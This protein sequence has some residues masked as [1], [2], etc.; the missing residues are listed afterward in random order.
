[1][2]SSIAANYAATYLG[3]I[4]G[5]VR[6]SDR[7]GNSLQVNGSSNTTS[8]NNVGPDTLQLSAKGRLLAMND[9]TLPTAS[10]V[11]ALSA[12][13]SRD[14]NDLFLKAGINTKTPVEI[15]IDEKTMAITVKGDR[16]DKEK[17]LELI[18]GSEKI[19]SQIRTV[20]AISSHAISMAEPLK[21]Q[22]EYRTSSY[23]ENAAARYSSSFDNRK[24]NDLSLMFDGNNIRVLSNG[25][26]RLSSSQS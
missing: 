10:N 21:L 9:L 11:Q 2:I 23:P 8:C 18:N 3:S 1:M 6:Q 25:V 17:I 5:K 20:A 26:Q 24:V 15:D 16:P 13:L 12:N 14:L 19:K 4:I 7:T 22:G